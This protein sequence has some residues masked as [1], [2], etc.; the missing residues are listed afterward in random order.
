M[1]SIERKSPQKL[2]DADLTP[3]GRVHKSPA[4]WRDQIFDVV[5]TRVTLWEKIT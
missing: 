5:Q 1:S 4:T 2:S 3:R